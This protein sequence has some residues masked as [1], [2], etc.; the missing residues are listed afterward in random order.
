MF[1]KDEK[2]P[3]LINIIDLW[4]NFSK[5]MEKNKCLIIIT[6]DDYFSKYLL[7][8]SRYFKMYMQTIQIIS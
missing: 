7:S 1:L 8:L 2:K 5:Y 3:I 6:D 4:M